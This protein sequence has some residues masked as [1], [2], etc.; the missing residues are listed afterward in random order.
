MPLGWFVLR[1]RKPTTNGILFR[2]ARLVDL[3]DRSQK[4]LELKQELFDFWIAD[5]CDVV[6]DPKQVSSLFVVAYIVQEL[7]DVA[8]LLFA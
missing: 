6:Q 4:I 3:F 2:A 1:H 8:E 7:D 5:V